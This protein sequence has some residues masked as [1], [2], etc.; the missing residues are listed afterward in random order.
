MI[1]CIDKDECKDLSVEN[2][3]NLGQ[4]SKL[5]ISSISSSPLGP[6]AW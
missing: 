5:S 2:E 6:L 4:D 1:C 3:E